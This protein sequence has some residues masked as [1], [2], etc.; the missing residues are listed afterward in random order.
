M[1]RFSNNVIIENEWFTSHCKAI[2][3]DCTIYNTKLIIKEEF[4]N[5]E[6][7]EN[8]MT[9]HTIMCNASAYPIK[10]LH[11]LLRALKIVSLKYP[12]VKLL[13]PGGKSL[14]EKS[15]FDRI[16]I[17]GYSNYLKRLIVKL[18]IQQN[19]QFLGLLSAEEM[20]DT[21]AKSN[22]FVMPSSIENIS[23]TLIEA[24]IVGTPCISSN[25]GGISDYLI[26]NE[27]G[28]LYRFDEYE[29]LA[30]NILRVFEDKEFAKK[31]SKNAMRKNRNS[32]TSGNVKQE[33]LQIYDTILN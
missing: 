26:N 12:D 5:K 29:I 18:D 20:A 1:I 32:R 6:W 3:S 15:F 19:I 4:Y 30:I 16:K 22:V 27:N 33:L 23:T 13:I 17:D 31:L 24:M 2:S 8:Q 9:P 7:N 21:M 14:F 10:G 11:M 25:V 28:L